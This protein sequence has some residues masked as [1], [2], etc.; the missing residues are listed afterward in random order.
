[1]GLLVICAMLPS[2]VLKPITIPG[3]T[4]SWRVDLGH[5]RPTRCDKL[6]G[7]ANALVEA[8]L[9]VNACTGCPHPFWP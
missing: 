1:M 2:A 6:C 4:N 8:R 5:E 7:Q 3:W 9:E